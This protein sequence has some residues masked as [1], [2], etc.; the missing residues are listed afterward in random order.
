[1]HSCPDSYK[2]WWWKARLGKCYY[3]LGLLRDS[4]KQFKS[5]IKTQD[6]VICYMELCKVYLKLDQPN[7]ALEWY[8]RGVERHAG[9]THLLLGIARIHDQLNDIEKGVAHYKRVLALD[10]VNVE[11]IACLASNHFYEDQPEIALRYFRRLLQMGVNSTEL[12]CNIGL[13]CFY[14]SQYDM[15]LNCFEQALALASDDNMADVWYNIG[16]V[17]IGIGDLGLAYQA[18]K[19]AISVDPNHA[20]SFNNL[21]VLELRKGNIDQAK[22]NF[23]TATRLAPHQH[24]STFNEGLLCFKLGDF[25]ESFQLAS[26]AMK[27]YPT[28]SESMDLLRQLRL[29]FA[30][31]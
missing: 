4:E 28:H 31:L 16:Q 19:V 17:A 13:C 14:A 2:D 7:T 27:V 3:Q 18:F 1:M 12:W 5:A 23:Q 6:M 8:Q 11:S 21:G 30:A 24:E 29:H 20:E 25:Q 9:D 10:P 26:K 22:T 15:T